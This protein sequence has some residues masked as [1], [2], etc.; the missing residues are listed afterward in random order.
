L[1]S[2]VYRTNRHQ[3][4]CN[5]RRKRA[6]WGGLVEWKGGRRRKVTIE[7]R[8]NPRRTSG[9]YSIPYAEIRPHAAPRNSRIELVVSRICRA[10]K[11]FRPLRALT[12]AILLFHPPRPAIPQY[13]R[14]SLRY[15]SWGAPPL[16]SP[17]P[18]VISIRGSPAGGFEGRTLGRVV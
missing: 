8:S 14:K 17:A 15:P 12:H 18:P 16:P 13:C 1:S 2:T 11:L 9:T 10:F 6:V 7:K 3:F 5:Q 4:N